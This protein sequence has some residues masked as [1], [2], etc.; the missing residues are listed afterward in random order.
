[1]KIVC[2]PGHGGH[3]SGAVN[4]KVRV[5]E[6][7]LNLQIAIALEGWLTSAGHKVLMTRSADYFVPLFDRAE[8][9]NKLG[10]D[11]FISIHCNAAGNPFAKGFEIWTS[12]GA[13]K[14]DSLATAIGQAIQANIPRLINRFDFT[15]GDLDKEGNL[16]VLRLTRCPAVLVEAGFVSEDSEAEWLKNPES[17]QAI[18]QAISLGVS[19]WATG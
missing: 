14:A 18:A 10:A 7:D 13:T 16:A 5:Q 15:D 3:D 9:A 17:I 1:M 2:D 6:K 8:L 12:L 11:A 19:M 4:M